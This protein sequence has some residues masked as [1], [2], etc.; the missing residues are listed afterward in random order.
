MSFLVIFSSSV[1]RL[2]T[3]YCK[4]S[5]LSSSCFLGLGGRNIIEMLEDASVDVNDGTERGKVLL[6]FNDT[7][8]DRIQVFLE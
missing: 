4:G 7:M 8:G 2:F 5:K 1:C 6:D 3:S